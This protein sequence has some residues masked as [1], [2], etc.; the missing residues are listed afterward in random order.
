MHN[1]SIAKLLFTDSLHR[2]LANLSIIGSPRLHLRN[3]INMH[4]YFMNINLFSDYAQANCLSWN[5]NVM[6]K[7]SLTLYTLIDGCIACT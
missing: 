3:L 5:K 4:E 6:E 7:Y 2:D 1:S